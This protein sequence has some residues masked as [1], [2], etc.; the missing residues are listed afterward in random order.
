MTITSIKET[1]KS[2]RRAAGR[3]ARKEGRM[4]GQE[5]RKVDEEIERDCHALTYTQKTIVIQNQ[6]Q[7]YSIGTL[8]EERWKSRMRH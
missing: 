4:P 7:S 3:K 2:K 5:L 8:E 1:N 6:Q